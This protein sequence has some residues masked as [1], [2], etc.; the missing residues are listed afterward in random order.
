MKDAVKILRVLLLP[1]LFGASAFADKP[2]TQIAQ[3]IGIDQKLNVQVP[4]NLEF[5]NEQGQSVH[6]SDYFG[7]KPVILS[8]VYY[9]CPMLCPMTLNALIGALRTLRLSAGTDF[10][11]LTVSFDPKDTPRESLEK[12]KQYAGQFK[13]PGAEN[14]WSFLT[15][16][17]EAIKTL[18]QTVG[19]RYTADNPSRQFAH[20]SGIIV[21]T[22]EGKISRYFYGV[23]Y[24]PRDLRLALIE[25]GK[26]KIGNL[27]DQLL[28]LCYHYDPLTGRYGFAVKNTLRVCGALMVIILAAYVTT[29][30]K[31]E[32][33]MTSKT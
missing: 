20:A 19:F 7:R 32:R 31:K 12:K 14:G 17:E 2:V 29:S 22:P 27:V 3:E 26:G 5:V 30:L 24:A 28:L 4:L 21:L 6:L 33:Q 16:R 18:L 13:R 1:V 11:I 15:G 9:Q 25:A 10:Q 8:L 23:E